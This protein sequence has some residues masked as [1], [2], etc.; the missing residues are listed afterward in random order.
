LRNGAVSS[1][2]QLRTSALAL[3]YDTEEAVEGK[4]AFMEKRKPNFAK[5]AK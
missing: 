1:A 4:N 3:Y 5:Y 2:W